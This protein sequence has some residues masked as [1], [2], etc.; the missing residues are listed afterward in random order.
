MAKFKIK[1]KDIVEELSG[2][3]RKFPKYTTQMINLANQ[4]AQGTRPRVVGQLSEL[5]QTC[6]YNEYEKWKVWYQDLH[7]NAID[8]ATEKI[9]EMVENMRKAIDKIDKDM[10]KEWVS[11]LVIDKT[12][13]GL[14]FQE[15]I[16]RRV[17]KMRKTDYRLSTALEE[18]RGIDGYVGEIPVSIKP[19]SYRAKNMLREEIEVKVI[20]YDK[21]K[22]GINVDIT[23]LE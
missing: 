12:F 20:F 5:I 9:F 22:D 3:T 18:K 19:I 16:L 6:P 21:K 14:K 4:N 17:A 2:V 7:P 8:N 13:A 10:V 15:A 1:N 23:G 11:D